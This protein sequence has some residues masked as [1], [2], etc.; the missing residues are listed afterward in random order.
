MK[1]W[2]IIIAGPTATG[3]TA[4][5]IEL[6]KHFSTSI[7]SADSRQCYKEL[8]IGVA[9]PTTEEINSIPHYFINSHS[10]HQNVTAADF[11]KFALNAA[12]EVFRKNDIVIM[13]GG[14]GLYIKAFCEGLDPIEP[15]EDSVRDTIIENYKKKGIQ[16]LQEE[17][18]TVDPIFYNQGEIYNPQRLMRALEVKITTGISIT[19]FQSGNKKPRDFD[20]LKIGLDLPRE[21][22][23]HRI[24]QR[25]DR[26]MKDGLLEEVKRLIRY[27]SLNAL[28]TVGYKELFLFLD[29]TITLEKAVEM[30][31]QNTRHYAKRQVT[32]FT[33]DPGIT[34]VAPDDTRKILEF[35]LINTSL[36][37]GT[38]KQ[39]A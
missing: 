30:I 10:I 36:P 28:Q 4:I 32:W 2:C 23:Y 37:G 8:E 39:S 1:K 11:E 27:R 33:K 31:K 20:I 34:W 7:I 6:A 26:M 38:R 13:V 12:N 16:W 5:A 15:V 3:K 17:V 19:S 18:K 21:E 9:K 35:I 25:T 24:N 22:L 29:R 14:T